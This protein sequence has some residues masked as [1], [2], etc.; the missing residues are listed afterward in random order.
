MSTLPANVLVNRKHSLGGLRVKKGMQVMLLFLGA[1]SAQVFAYP[2]IDRVVP[3]GGEPVAVYAD[4][5]VDGVYWY[6]PQSI[7][8]WARDGRYKS[9]LYYK[10][11][12]VLS[13]VFRG[14]ASVDPEMLKRVAKALRTD[15][16]NL[17]PISYDTND[18]LVCHNVYAA[19]SLTWLFPSHIG[20][21]LEVVPI[22]IRTEDPSVVDE[23]HDMITKLGGLSCS[24]DVTFKAVATGY[25]LNMTADMNTV[26]SRFES[27]M[28]V[29]YL[30]YEAD[31]HAMVQNL[32]HDGVIQLTKIEDVNAPKT[33]LDQQVQSAW[34]DITRQVIAL[35]FK[36]EVKLPGGELPT[37]RGLPF[38]LR[39][40]Y[41]RSEEHK[42]WRV[43]LDSR[44]I[45]SKSTH[46]SLRLATE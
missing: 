37:G 11:G 20:N 2:V 39:M 26:Y 15:V 36:Q 17:T 7:E 14:Q 34:D 29:S 18:N 40:D 3:T 16:A 46:I 4:S 38:S 41:Q 24:V 27:A 32:V 1:W 44:N 45:S 42:R 25:L 28:G 22:S 23:V 21:Y 12:R 31:V 43:T 8:P 6:I 10:P 13:F 35:M 9:A 33:S 30:W 19:K 5:F